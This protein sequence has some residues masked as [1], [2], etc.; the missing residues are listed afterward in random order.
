[1]NLRTQ[2]RVAADV[3]G[4]S[5]KKV[6]FDSTRLPEIKESITKADIRSLIAQGV[7]RPKPNKGVSRV[8]ARKTLV[9]KRKGRRQG[10]GSRKGKS[11]ARLGRKE[12]WV[13]LIRAQRELLKILKNKKLLTLKV[14]Q[15]LRRKAKGGF[16]RSKRHIQLYIKDRG[17]VKDGKQ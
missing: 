13:I 11:T 14:Y 5:I 3:L 16:F 1:M 12:K 10:K 4:V 8:R 15:N 7:I 2:K 17:L 9:Q 6:W